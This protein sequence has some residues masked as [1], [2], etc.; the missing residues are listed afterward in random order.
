MEELRERIWEHPVE[1]AESVLGNNLADNATYHLGVLTGEAEACAFAPPHAVEELGE[2]ERP[3]LLPNA[4]RLAHSIGE[5]LGQRAKLLIGESLPKCD[6]RRLR[7]RSR[8][9]RSGEPA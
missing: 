3:R 6:P 4:E 5:K 9:R 8:F 2:V 7:R 1:C